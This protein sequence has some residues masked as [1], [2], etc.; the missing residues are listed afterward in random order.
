[1]DAIVREKSS[2]VELRLLELGLKKE[3]L[4]SIVKSCA[5]GHGGCTDNDPPGARGW[6]SWRWGVRRAREELR[7]N[8]WE[9]DDTGNFST[10]VNHERKI[11]LAILNADGGAGTRDCVPQNR[12]RKGPN[13]ERVATTN[14]ELMPGAE[15]WPI[16]AGE[17]KQSLDD[18]CTWHLCVNIERDEVCAELALLSD[19]V[20]GYFTGFI[21]K[22][23]IV[24]P[25]EWIAL[26]T[27][28]DDDYPDLEFEVARK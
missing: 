22:I 15:D 7:P 25:G 5:A 21:E 14:R 12:S 16:P 18:Y 9:K 2:D 13:S 11:R 8:G 3:Q 17:I 6:E 26:P 10:V 19:F 1:M 23:I 28:E 24:G 4:V 20:G 27:N